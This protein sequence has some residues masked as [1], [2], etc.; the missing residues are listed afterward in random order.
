MTKW[1]NRTRER[2]GQNK[3][4]GD[5]SSEIEEEKGKQNKTKNKK[6][7]KTNRNKRKKKKMNGSILHQK[8]TKKEQT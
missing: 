4:N 2:K 1:T 8:S 6:Q 3:P 7:Q 5:L